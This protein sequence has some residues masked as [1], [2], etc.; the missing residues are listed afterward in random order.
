MKKSLLFTTVLFV[1]LVSGLSV[2]LNY[3]IQFVVDAISNHDTSSFFMQISY[4]IGITL[5]LLVFEYARQVWNVK[6]LNQVGSFFHKKSL[7]LS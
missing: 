5:L 6:Y 7:Y 1:M 3:Q 4:L 2:W